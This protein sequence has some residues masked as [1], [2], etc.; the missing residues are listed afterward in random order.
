M[1]MVSEDQS[2]SMEFW[3]RAS[4]LVSSQIWKSFSKCGTDDTLQSQLCPPFWQGPNTR[5]NFQSDQKNTRGGG[6]GLGFLEVPKRAPRNHS[7]PDTEWAGVAHNSFGWA[8]FAL[9]SARH[10][11]RGAGQ[12]PCGGRCHCHLWHFRSGSVWGWG[13]SPVSSRHSLCAVSWRR[14]CLSRF[15]HLPWAMKCWGAGGG[16]W[17]LESFLKLLLHSTMRF[18]EKLNEC[19][20]VLQILWQMMI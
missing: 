8:A 16:G 1:F 12:P 15:P 20:P 10:R 18:K 5:G 19:D 17:E 7:S 3:V 9:V 6:P 2:I 13:P 14:C 4:R 11:G